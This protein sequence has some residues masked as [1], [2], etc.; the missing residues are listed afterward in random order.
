MHVFITGGAGFIGSHIVEYHLNQNDIVHVIDDLSTGIEKNIQPFKSNPNFH[1]IKADLLIYPDLKEEVCWADRIYHM[2]AVVGVFKV[3]NDSEKLLSTN[4][5]ATER[6]LRAARLSDRNPRI[7]LASTS[8]VYGEG[9]AKPLSEDLNLIIGEGRKSCS[10][11]AVSKIAVEYFGISYYEHFKLP[12]TI[13]RI[14]NTIG[15]RQLS[16]Y[17]MVIPRFID[18]ALK[19]KPILVYGTGEQTRSFCDVRDVVSMMDKIANNPMTIGK[20]LNV[21]SDAEISINEVAKLVKKLAKS[22]SEIK[23]ITYDEAYGEGFEDFMY[24]RP[25]LTKLRS[26][27]KYKDA[28]NLEK[29]LIDLIA[30]K[31]KD[32]LK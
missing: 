14:F 30:R 18:S 1:F 13:L 25:E 6:L 11:Y 16:A 17:G 3:I 32:M 19:N 26:L 8:E 24:R 4:I 29:T 27:I 2:A 7:L 31:R 22:D 5:A 28:W 21:G 15:P 12:I 10:A 20:I 9:H 23:H